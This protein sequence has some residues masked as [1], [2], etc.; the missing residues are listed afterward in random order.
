MARDIPLRHMAKFLAANAGTPFEPPLV[1]PGEMQLYSY[2]R[3][4]LLAGD[5]SINVEQVIESDSYESKDPPND[6]DKGWRRKKLTKQNR[7]E[8]SQN[9]F[10]PAP[11]EFEVMAP[12]F[13]IERSM[14]N[15]YYPPDGHQD[16]ARIL[17]HIVLNDPHFPWERH[18]G[19]GVLMPDLCDPDLES[20][21]V[22]PKTSDP[23]TNMF[24]S[25]VPWLAVMVFDPAELILPVDF[26]PYLIKDSPSID[27]KLDRQ[28]LSGAFAMQVQEYMHL[29]LGSRI[30]Y[31]AGF[32]TDTK[33]LDELKASNEAMTAIFPTK[34]TFLK[35]FTQTA[36]DGTM[37]SNVEGNKYLAHMRAV[38]TEGFPDAG[39]EQVGNYSIVVSGRTARLDLTVPTTQIC[40]LISIEHVDS[41]LQGVHDAVKTDNDAIAA[42]LLADPKSTKVA[43][44]GMERIAM[45]SL[46]SW[47]YTALPPHPWDFVED[48]REI[49]KSMQMLK[50]PQSLLDVLVE[51]SKVTSGTPAVATKQAKTAGALHKRLDAGYSLAR[52]RTETG[53]ETAAFSR[54][55]LVPQRVQWPP[56]DD[57]CAGSNTSKEYQILD[58]ATGL[59]DLS[60]SSAWQLGKACAIADT[61]FNAALMRFRSLV[62]NWAVSKVHSDDNGVSSTHTIIAGLTD[63]MKT[64]KSLAKGTST[65]EPQRIVQPTARTLPPHAIDDPAI[66]PRIALAMKDEI[67]K[68]T[69]AG[70][71]IW[72]EFSLDKP[73]NSDWPLVSSWLANKLSLADIPAHF[74]IPDPSFLPNE[75][76]RFFHIDR[77]WT[78][79]LIDGA[80][81]V[82]NHLDRDD[83]LVRD[84]IK[85][86]FN[87]Y[88]KADVGGAHM[89]VP[90]NGF[91]LRSQIVQVMPDLRITVT[92]TGDD[93]KKTDSR[94][95]YCRYTKLDD[96]T[97][98]CL[99]DRQVEEL[100]NITFAQPPHQ[101]RFSLGSSLTTT[102]LPKFN[103][104]KLYTR[105]PLVGKD[106]PTLSPS[107]SDTE[108]AAWYDVDSRMVRVTPL[109]KA[110]NAKLTFGS[111]SG[112]GEAYLD[113]VPNSAELAMELND[114]AYYFKITPSTSISKL[115]ETDIR[116]LW[117]ANSRDWTTDPVETEDTSATAGMGEKEP[118]G[119]S[120]GDPKNNIRIQAPFDPPARAVAST[121][122]T[123]TGKPA[124][125][126]PI[127]NS[128]RQSWFSLDV[129]PDYKGKPPKWDR[130]AYD[131]NGYIPMKND[132]LF[133]LIFVIRKSSSGNA[134][135]LAE[136]VVNLPHSGVTDVEALVDVNY[137]DPRAR[138]L[139]N[140]R[141][142][143][144]INWTTTHIQI[145]VVPRSAK[146]RPTIVMN[147][148]RTRD[149]SFRLAEVPI[150]LGIG[151]TSVNVHG[152]GQ[153]PGFR[154]KVRW[155]EKYY[156]DD[157]RAFVS[158]PG[159]GK[160]IKEL[161]KVD[162]GDPGK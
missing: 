58:P 86:V 59:I 53:E 56:R 105:S 1:K 121:N 9:V 92:W 91:I 93:P 39:V 37:Q 65:P 96:I 27:L 129:F 122:V 113:Y 24:R 111:A 87:E 45:V 15:S 64:L 104:T 4:G 17:P 79:C 89:Q 126:S 81:S 88:L 95:P 123:V 43:T 110:I 72:T 5:Y 44:V 41:T 140:Q 100:D 114:K 120:Q 14:V 12:Q 85:G 80:L 70:S 68:Q 6:H 125:I 19:A 108:A 2:Y 48:T 124:D 29:A 31:D 157:M 159:G 34:A 102:G 60:Y 38:N 135:N 11:Q 46:F 22:T 139:S 7:R 52:W 112:K 40:H 116:Q 36:A 30:N 33:G 160:G 131:P 149:L 151:P 137:N 21:R 158:V 76:L 8:A 69:S 16:E 78:D 82:A 73:N 20:D 145:R 10:I 66:R 49:M 54:G 127:M 57:W 132:Y 13:A 162:S 142:V 143:V 35:L 18:A 103:L 23:P 146:P 28:P 153:Q 144:Y 84:Y 61:A 130:D 101:Q 154:T 155:E 98:L 32:A 115:G 119:I 109:A 3:P 147:D 134:Q 55:P 106:W 107:P 51:A 141:F 77:N 150:A 67:A 156:T 62:Y 83:D 25:A 152:Q 74:L 75:S 117:C 118:D 63:K 138:M 94:A 128:N 97:L 136:V 42:E 161:W 47:T 148:E 26:K 50:P 71:A 99:L 90:F 133:D